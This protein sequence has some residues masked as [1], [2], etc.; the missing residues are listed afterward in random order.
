MPLY[1][2]NHFCRLAKLT[3]FPHQKF[4]SKNTDNYSLDPYLR[5]FLKCMV[6]TINLEEESL[7]LSLRPL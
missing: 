3:L 4:Y 2:L 7:L 5:N 1:N 6:T